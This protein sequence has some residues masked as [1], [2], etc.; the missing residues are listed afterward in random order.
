M[1]AADP[2]HPRL[3]LDPPAVPPTSDPQRSGRA[4]AVAASRASSQTTPQ[5]LLRS[6]QGV[7]PETSPRQVRLERPREPLRRA[8]IRLA[9]SSGMQNPLLAT[10][11]WRNGGR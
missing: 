8:P 7:F 9:R 11:N 2:R 1:L 3:P 10:K 6:L 4:I 5:A